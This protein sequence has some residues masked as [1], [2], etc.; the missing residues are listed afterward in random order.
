MT[1]V[2]LNGVPLRFDHVTHAPAP[3]QS[4]QELMPLATREHLDTLGIVHRLATPITRPNPMRAWG[5][6]EDLRTNHRV[7]GM[8]PYRDE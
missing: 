1:K 8:D 4:R 7:H 2:C 5:C 3:E 6:G